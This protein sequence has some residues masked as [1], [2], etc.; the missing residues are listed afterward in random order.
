MQLGKYMMVEH[1][2][3]ET[4][5]NTRQSGANYPKQW[6]QQDHFGH[7]NVRTKGQPDP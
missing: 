1:N 2:N 3:Q 7:P 6:R 5:S 4:G